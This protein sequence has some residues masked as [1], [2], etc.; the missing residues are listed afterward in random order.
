MLPPAGCNT[1]SSSYPATLRCSDDYRQGKVCK[2]SIF[3]E[4]G[5]E[6]LH[7]MRNH[8]ILADPTMMRT[9]LTHSV[10]ETRQVWLSAD[11]DVDP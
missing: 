9:A 10:A 11:E 2:T 7:R 1:S 6:I 8:N 4:A 5:K 3:I